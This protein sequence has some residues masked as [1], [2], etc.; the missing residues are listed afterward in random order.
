M[1]AEPVGK[2]R[3]RK[4]RKSE[5]PARGFLPSTGQVA[6]YADCRAE[7]VQTEGAR[8]VSVSGSTMDP[9]TLKPA[10]AWRETL[11]TGYRPARIA[12]MTARHTAVA[13]ITGSR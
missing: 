3:V 1:Q 9:V 10:G 5:D 13:S 11:Q 2:E 4:G 7:S 6:V 8:V 12:E